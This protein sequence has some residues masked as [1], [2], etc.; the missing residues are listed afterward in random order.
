MRSSYGM[1][2]SFKFELNNSKFIIKQRKYKNETKLYV[3][4]RKN[5]RCR[6][7]RINTIP[8]TVVSFSPNMS[9]N[10]WNFRYFLV[11]QRK[12]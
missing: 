12:K 9:I 4:H 1:V 6:Q 11:T 5:T 2:K 8:I 3:I 7:M 10:V